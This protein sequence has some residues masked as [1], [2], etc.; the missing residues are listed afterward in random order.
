MWRCAAARPGECEAGKQQA[1]EVPPWR[2]A[3]EV[4]A[5]HRV[6][7]QLRSIIC[8]FEPLGEPRADL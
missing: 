1:Q 7:W 6:C 2:H 5:G 3:L 8:G 4:S